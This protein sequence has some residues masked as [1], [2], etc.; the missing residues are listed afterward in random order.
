MAV[1]NSKNITANKIALLNAGLLSLII[2]IISL[3]ILENKW[4]VIWIALSTAI[5]SYF[6]FL[7]SLR[8]FIYRKIKVIYKLIMQTKASK[9]EEYFYEQIVAEKSIDEVKEEVEK[10][11]NIKN[12][13]I[14]HLKDNEEF[15]K[16][17][18]M[19]LAHE[20]RTPIFTTQ[21]YIH[22]LL[23]EDFNDEEQRKH[24]LENA[25]IGIDRLA[26][27]THDIDQISKLEY[28]VA[29]LAYNSFII[30][31]LVKDVFNEFEMT[32]KEKTVQLS[33]KP[34]TEA[35]VMVYADKPKIHQVLINLIGNAIKYGYTGTQV[36]AG[37]YI[38][39]KEKVLVEISD[40]G[41][42]IK[43]ENLAR[44]FERF[45]RSD[46]NRDRKIGGTGLGLSIVKHIIEAHGQTV[47]VRSK[48]SV[49]TTFG[50]TLDIHR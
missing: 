35:P 8:F 4:D 37:F 34:G 2:S 48:S 18:L 47:S 7:S 39:D 24:F 42:G 27:L 10:W 1:Y 30:Q 3:L 12:I 40:N 5:V 19:N 11:A 43:E 32:A 16:E 49:G 45:F 13:E 22:T 20:L 46:K 14:Q 36:H 21:G 15:R 44:I 33:L 17:F 28:G 25:A 26:D 41:P 31:E 23:N 29:P 9:K 50:F 6:I 38:I